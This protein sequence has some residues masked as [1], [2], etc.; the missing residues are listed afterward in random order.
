MIKI[1][2]NG[3][4]FDPAT[5]ENDTL[6]AVLLLAAEEIR[7][8]I[9]SIRDPDT[10]EFPTVVIC[11][12]P[13]APLSLRIEG[14]DAMIERVK[15][16]LNKDKD[17]P[18]GQAAAVTGPPLVF[19]SYASE[20][21][22]IAERVARD[23][24]ARGID[25]WWD[26]WEIKSGDSLRR[27][28]DEGLTRCTHF[29]VLLSSASAT[30]PW[31]NEEIDAGLVRKLDGA[32]KLVVLRLDLPVT[33]LSPLLRTAYSPEIQKKDFDLTQLANDISGVARKPALGARSS[34]LE[35]AR[36]DSGLSPA[37]EAI[38]K[39]YVEQTKN[40]LRFDPQYS[41]AE[42]AAQTDL[43]VEDVEDALHELRDVMH[44]HSADLIVAETELYARF[45][46]FWKDW[47][48]AEDA[49]TLAS[50]LL[51]EAGFP[52]SSR[53]ISERLNWTPRRLNSALGYLDHRDLVHARKAMGDPDYVIFSVSPTAATRRFFKSRTLD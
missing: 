42:V 24:I 32:A 52:T 29:V 22:D 28:I 12:D 41:P 48:P 6:A 30:K 11:A 18:A 39:L 49:V 17:P 15:E 40:A 13:I 7:Q 9:S 20:D 3:K 45:D 53:Q 26:Q 14:S 37:A 4:P 38:A 43:S 47:N 23:L 21:R 8:R 51:N 33:A 27:K 31:V 1:E 46:H 44:I 35:S 2:F 34:V 5:F 50:G 19:L 16:A 36:T 10:G 25:V